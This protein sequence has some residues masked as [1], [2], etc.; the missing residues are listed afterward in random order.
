MIFRPSRKNGAG[1]RAAKRRKTSPESEDEFEAPAGD[2]GYSDDG[3]A[4]NLHMAILVPR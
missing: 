4:P 3:K 2:G 1:G